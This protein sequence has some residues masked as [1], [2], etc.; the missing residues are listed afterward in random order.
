MIRSLSIYLVPGLVI[1][2]VLVGGGF[3]TGRELV[4]FF[5]SMGPASALAAM[6]LTAALFSA[7]SAISFELARRHQTFDYNSFMGLILGRFRILFELVYFAGLLLVLAIVSAAASEILFSLTDAPRWL[8]ALLFMIF[9]GAL[10]FFGSAGLERFNTVWSLI[11]YILYGALLALVLSRFAGD[12]PAAMASTPLKPSAAAWNGLSYAAYNVPLVQV[13]IFLARRFSTRREAV[14]AGLLAGPFILLPGFALLFSLSA[15]YPEI[16]DAPLP[17][18]VAL[19]RVGQPSLSFIIQIVILGALITT[20]AGLIHGF[21]ERLARKAEEHGRAFSRLLRSLV[22]LALLAGAG[23]AATTIGLIDLIG[24]G[25]RFA[26]IFYI[27]VLI[28]PLLT[29]GAWRFFSEQ[30][31]ENMKEKASD[32]GGA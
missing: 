1:Q 17:I 20:G 28:V 7:C 13:L 12:L 16:V 15:F 3:A 18:L 27:F 24:R 31:R 26:A 19:E 8:G 14:A 23:F 32:S 9:V 29:V 10:V 4:E 21:N 5:L 2:A 11:F 30:S 6:A 22:A 25:Y